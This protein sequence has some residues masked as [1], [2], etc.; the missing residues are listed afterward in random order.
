MS[1]ITIQTVGSDHRPQEP[2]QLH[3]G[4]LFLSLLHV[5][6]DDCIAFHTCVHNG[7]M[8][9]GVAHESAE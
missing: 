2:Y 4:N 8:M 7:I 3:D 1:A 6:C 5:I 9:D